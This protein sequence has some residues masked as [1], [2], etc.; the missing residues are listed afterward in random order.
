M[1]DVDKGLDNARQFVNAAPAHEVG[2]AGTLSE[3]S[4]AHSMVVIAMLLKEL[5]DKMEY[6]CETL[7]SIRNRLGGPL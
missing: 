2:I 6:I 1:D 3:A 5:V 7:D 4:M